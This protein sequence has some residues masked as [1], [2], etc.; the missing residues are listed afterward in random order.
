MSITPS[1]LFTSLVPTGGLFSVRQ[2]SAV[3]TAKG[4]VGGARG[5]CRQL[6]LASTETRGVHVDTATELTSLQTQGVA[7]VKTRC[8]TTALS[9]WL[10]VLT[11]CEQ[12]I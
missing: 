8:R 10:L 1:H 7:L 4:V 3:L 12:I 6:Y 11:K 5:G 2:R 9:E